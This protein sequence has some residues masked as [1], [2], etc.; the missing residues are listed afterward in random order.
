MSGIAHSRRKLFSFVSGFHR[1]FFLRLSMYAVAFVA[2][3]AFSVYSWVH[4]FTS[5]LIELVPSLGPEGIETLEASIHS[6]LLL[7][8]TFLLL[9]V[10]IALLLLIQLSRKVAG[11]LHA[12]SRDIVKMNETHSTFPI[13]VRKGDLFVE[14]VDQLNVLNGHG[15]VPH[16]SE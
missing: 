11:P 6:S 14:M 12:I 16:A 1:W 5:R 3:L 15:Q 7:G 8:L 10:L 9:L 13:Q 4:Y 2:L